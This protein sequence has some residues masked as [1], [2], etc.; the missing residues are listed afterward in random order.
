MQGYLDAKGI[1]R[2]LGVKVETVYVYRYRAQQFRRGTH[3]G[4]VD[5]GEDTQMPDPVGKVGN[6]PIWDESEIE[7]WVTRRR[8]KGWRSSV[9]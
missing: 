1:A 6:S 7:D 4:T 8:G 9:G 5:L 3:K 2:R